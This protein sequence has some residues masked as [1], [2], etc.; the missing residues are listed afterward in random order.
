MGSD[1]VEVAERPYPSSIKVHHAMCAELLKIV[2]KVSSILPEIEAAR[3]RCSAGIEALCLLNR[4]I[5]KANLLLQ[6]CSESSKLYLALTGDAIV[7]R[8]ERSRN[9]LEQSLGQLHNMVPVL[10]AIEISKLLD[11]LRSATFILEPSEE[12]AGKAVHDLIRQGPSESGSTENSE[13]KALQFASSKLFITSPKSI[14]VE[15][16]SIKKLLDKIGESDPKKKK[17]LLYLSSLLK[18]YGNSIVSG[19]TKSVCME[20]EGTY[21]TADSRQSTVYTATAEVAE[22]PLPGH[23][24]AQVDV[25]VDTILPEEFKC[26]LSSRLMYEPVVI[27]SGQT[28]ERMWIQK[29]FDEGNTFCPKTKKNLAHQL[30]TPNTALK[31]LIS[32]WCTRHGLEIPD[33]IIQRGSVHHLDNSSTSIASLGSSLNDLRLQVDF[34]NV[35]LGS[36]G[37]SN[38]SE[39]SFRRFANAFNPVTLHS[40]DTKQDHSYGSVDEE[41]FDIFPK[42]SEL[43]WQSQC[44]VVEDFKSNLEYNHQSLH[45]ASTEN[46][47]EPLVRFLGESRDLGDVKAQKTALQL[48]LTYLKKSRYEVMHVHQDGF[49]MLAS[50]LDSEVAEQAIAIVE[51]LSAQPDC[52]LKV[53]NSGAISSILETLDCEIRDLH[54][55]ALKILYNLCLST[56]LRPYVMPCIPKL[57]PFLKDSELAKYALLIVRNLCDIEEARISITETLECIASIAELLETGSKEEQEHAVAIFL[58]LCSQRVQYCQLV[59]DEGFA[60]IP[61][62][63]SISINGTERSKVCAMELL[64]LLRDANDSDGCDFSDLDPPTHGDPGYHCPE[65]KPSSR[66]SGF[67]GRKLSIFSKK[68]VSAMPRKTK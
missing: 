52:R 49:S 59:L 2:D 46:F 45:L 19:Q 37:S 57:V 9:M 8:C 15:R 30:W 34:S 66:T 54:E 4:A 65:T 6:H 29:W 35:S 16:R 40:R 31:G 27:D 24:E 21:L 48:L 62:L 36:L 18:K 7:A 60:V 32:Q 13:I 38:N 50:F 56:D 64:R 67:F 28:F 22:T 53:V 25:F 3:P 26:P 1:V 23:R 17:I 33:P 47:L 14:L 51:I 44:K 10:L 42:L 39:S 43:P 41:C 5:E 63:V 58:S 55:S 68:P 20:N 12:D 11:N 61:A